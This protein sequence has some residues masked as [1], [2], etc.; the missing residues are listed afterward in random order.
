[1]RLYDRLFRVPFPGAR[2]AQGVAGETAGDAAPRPHHAVAS[3]GDDD[4][5]PDERERS[6]L[7]DLN[8]DSK[9]VIAAYV[10]PALAGAAPEER[11]QFERNGYFI[12][13]LLDHR[14]EK[15]V[16]NRTVTLRDSWAKPPGA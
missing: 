12:A 1:V 16:F 10:E 7:D 3:A 4:E 8:P 11:F 13:D 5:T 2:E 6:F 14:S 9:R 15:P